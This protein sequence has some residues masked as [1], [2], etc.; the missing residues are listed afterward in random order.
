MD[1]LVA[2]NLLFSKCISFYYDRV[3]KAIDDFKNA[4]NNLVE[5]NPL[6]H[7]THRKL[8]DLVDLS[9]LRQFYEKYSDYDSARLKS[10][11][12]NGSLSWLHVPYN[13]HYGVEFSNNQFIILKSLILGSIVTNKKDNI[14][15]LCKCK[16]DQYG[17]HALSCP[18][19]GMI[20]LRHDSSCDKLFDY[21]QQAGYDVQKE[22]RYENNIKINNYYTTANLPKDCKSRHLYI[23]LT[24]AN[25]LAP[26]Y[27]KIAAK[28]RG[29]IASQ[30]QQ[31][32]LKKYQN[33]PNIF[34]IGIE[35]LGAMSSNGKILINEI[36]K[37]LEIKNNIDKSIHINR[38]RSNLLATM[39][40]HNANMIIKCYDS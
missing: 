9:L 21:C 22:Q 4:T 23:D 30:K 38:I 40:Q 39:M 32:K 1:E 11:S 19:K 12:N 31:H 15:R 3:K 16:M 25:I 24:F 14:C 36:A 8:I 20:T 13:V 28:H 6:Q 33:N 2:S 27:V 18:M 35:V 34:G 37:R 26:S 7:R 17:R 29:K 10:L 5:Y